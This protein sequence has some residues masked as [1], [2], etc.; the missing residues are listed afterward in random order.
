MKQEEI[1]RRKLGIGLLVTVCII[2]GVA[3]GVSTLV[4][5]SLMPPELPFS[6]NITVYDIPIPEQF[7]RMF[8]DTP[9]I[10]DLNLRFYRTNMTSFQ[11]LENFSRYMKSNNYKCEKVG[12]LYMDIERGYF[13]DSYHEGFSTIE[14]YGY[15][16]LLNAAGF[17]V[18]N[19][20]DYR[21][22][23]YTSSFLANY[24]DI[25]RWLGA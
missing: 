17:I 24:Y 18:M 11:V 9:H 6:D 3:S 1:S 4:V 8:T 25:I 15:R 12:M 5:S 22:V 20:G 23:M 13:C 2:L 19:D 16:N 10:N 21:Y 14:Y 7:Q